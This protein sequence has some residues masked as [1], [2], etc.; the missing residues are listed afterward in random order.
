MPPV[1]ECQ[2]VISL[3]FH[4]REN[5]GIHEIKLEGSLTFEA[6]EIF[7]ELVGS[8]DKKNIVS[9]DLSSVNFMDSAGLGM[10][11]LLQDAAAS[12]SV[13][14]ACGQVARLLTVIHFDDLLRIP[15]R[16]G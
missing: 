4:L 8:I 2:G 13:N 9:L 16:Q 3:D 15:G 11:L 12:L 7:R 14:G 10:L 1:E 6:Q 5:N